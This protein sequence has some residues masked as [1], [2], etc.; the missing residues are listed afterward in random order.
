MFVAHASAV[1]PLGKNRQVKSP[2]N[3]TEHSMTRGGGG[4]NSSQASPIAA[5]RRAVVPPP[6]PH[7][8]C[9]AMNRVRREKTTFKDLSRGGLTN[10]RTDQCQ[11]WFPGPASCFVFPSQLQQVEFLSRRNCIRL[12]T[13]TLILSSPLISRSTTGSG[14]KRDR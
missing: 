1:Y 4:I 3:W 14:E 2:N 13:M 6:H 5:L 11:A 8:A 7:V 10:S 12:C 9:A